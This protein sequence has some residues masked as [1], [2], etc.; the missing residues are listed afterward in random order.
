MLTLEA[1]IEDKKTVPN[2]LRSVFEQTEIIFDLINNDKKVKFLKT[3]RDSD[4]WEYKYNQ[5][6]EPLKGQKC[7]VEIPRE[8]FFPDPV[9]YPVKKF[10]PVKG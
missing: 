8:K 4:W 2:R 5:F 1:V 7:I 3:G 6:D 9:E 10:Y